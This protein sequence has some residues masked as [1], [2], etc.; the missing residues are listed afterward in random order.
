M[1]CVENTWIFVTKSSV[2]LG[3]VSLQ[4]NLIRNH[5]FRLLRIVK[6]FHSWDTCCWSKKT[7]HKQQINYSRV[8]FLSKSPLTFVPQIAFLVEYLWLSSAE[9]APLYPSQQVL[10]ALV[11]SNVRA[12][13]LYLCNKTYCSLHSAEFKQLCN[14]LEQNTVHYWTLVQLNFT[15][16]I[17]IKS[18][19]IPNTFFKY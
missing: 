11:A 14:D 16:S 4:E 12:A 2:I 18:L 9:D 13:L 17:E 7:L 6:A 8:N 1:L 19:S 5:I 3:F 10:A 15:A